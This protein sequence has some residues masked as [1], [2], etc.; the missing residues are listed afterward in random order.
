[1]FRSMKMSTPHDMP[2][3]MLA[4]P[5]QYITK[6]GRFI[7]KYSL[8]ELPQI[9]DILSGKMSIIGPRPALWNQDDLVAEREKWGANDVVPGLTGW[10]QINGRDELE[11]P[12]K[13][14]LDGEY[15]DE[16]QKGGAQAMVMDA[17][18]FL[19]TVSSV[20]HHDGVVE[21]GTG[22]LDFHDYTVSDE[23]KISII[24]PAYN[25]ASFISESIESVLAQ[26]YKNWE[27][28]VVDDCS[29]DN[30]AE[31]VEEL[32]KE[33]PR[34]KLIR[35]EVNQ[36]VA[37]TRN[38]AL[39]AAD[40]DF[41]A[42]LDSDDKW[43]E[44]KLEFQLGFMLKNDYVLTYTS[45]QKF[46]SDTGVCG[47]TIICPDKMTAKD[48]YKNTAIAC[49]T[50][51]VNRRAVGAFHMPPLNH[52]EDQI[53]W[54]EILNRGFVAYGLKDT[55]A[56]YREGNTSLTCNQKASAKKQW[57]TYRGYYGF[58][59]VRSAYYFS[60]YALNAVKKHF[61]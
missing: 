19:G 55:L 11:I 61:M 20:L 39:D 21:G 8:D 35:H 16:L 60:F 2:T 15:C 59:L 1:K 18:C 54:Q 17:K 49:L 30:T 40:G 6:V 22:G 36:G 42:F 50:V 14:K 37:A 7:R 58:S 3:H 28:I 29:T 51:M 32:Q 24:M 52:T 25:A 26:T 53:T 31:I 5:D 47:K 4:N 27:L 46:D 12:V 44:N 10:A 23:H 13:A 34:I 45:Y 9:W 41:I 48:I 38:T 43:T 56:Y 33:D 57:E